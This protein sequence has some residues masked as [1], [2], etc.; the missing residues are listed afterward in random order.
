MNGPLLDDHSGEDVALS[1]E[2]SFRIGGKAREYHTPS[3][4]GELRELLGELRRRRPFILGGSSNTLFPDG[5]FER[6]VI[7]TAG[8][9]GL[10]VGERSILSECGVPLGTLISRAIEHGLGGLEGF[11]GIPGTVGGAVV[12]NAG[13]SGSSFGDR[14]AKLGLISLE[15]AELV[16]VPGAEIPWG[17][18]GWNLEGYVVAW[19][20]LELEPVSTLEL[21]RRAGSLFH[22]KRDTQPLAEPSAGCVF[23]NPPGHAAAA[24]ID[25]LGLKGLRR[26]GAMVS[27]RHANFIVNPEGRARAED[28]RQLIDEIRGRVEVEYG[29][30]LETEIVMA[31]GGTE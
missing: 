24:L 15:S 21:R 17:Y 18:R 27:R 28:V 19:A 25:R 14:V 4:V 16:E 10:D 6:P 7:S 12:M 23:K 8:L 3:T 13:G 22:R 5:T 9:R 26:G 11:V 31:D 2:T 20:L 30:R 1:G 29:I